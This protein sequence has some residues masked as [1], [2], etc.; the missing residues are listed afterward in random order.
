MTTS[1][2]LSREEYKRRYLERQA[3]IDWMQARRDLSLTAKLIGGRIGL[4]KNLETGR[5]DPGAGTLADEAG[6]HERAAFRAISELERKGCIAI[7]RT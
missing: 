1:R 4:H 7:E 2:K 3:W 5:C 6:I